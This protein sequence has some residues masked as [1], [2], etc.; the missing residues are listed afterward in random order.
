[1]EIPRKTDKMWEN[2]TM[3]IWLSVFQL[4]KS[5][6]ENITMNLI[7]PDIKRDKIENEKYYYF[8]SSL[9]EYKYT[10]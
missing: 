5:F 2:K 1:M 4:I 6:L 8:T 10:L 3:H 9:Y 7:I